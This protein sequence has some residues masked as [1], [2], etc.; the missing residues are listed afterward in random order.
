MIETRDRGEPSSKR[1]APRTLCDSRSTLLKVD[2]P[3]RRCSITGPASRLASGVASRCDRASNGLPGFDLRTRGLAAWPD[4][5]TPNCIIR[6]RSSRTAQCSTILLST[7]LQICTIS[8]AVV[9]PAAWRSPGTTPLT[10]CFRVRLGRPRTRRRRLGPCRG[11][12]L[13]RGAMS[14]R[15]PSIP[16]AATSSALPADEVGATLPVHSTIRPWS[17]AQTCWRHSES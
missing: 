17:A 16:A 10:R 7:N 1:G 3:R 9:T 2:S 4:S 6:A 12:S 11:A 14:R 8:T 13:V 5:T 15:Q